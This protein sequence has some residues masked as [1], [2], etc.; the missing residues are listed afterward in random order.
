MRQ[1]ICKR[2]LALV[3]PVPL[4]LGTTA[5]G[6]QPRAN[7]TN[8][9]ASADAGLNQS[10][11]AERAN[12]SLRTAAE[13]FEAVTEQAFTAEWDRLDGL[14]SEADA[15]VGTVRP[16]L[17][18]E[19][20]ATIERQLSALHSARSAQDRNGIAMAAVESYRALVQAQDPGTAEPPVPVSLLDYA[21]F[22]YDALAQARSP[23]WPEML[24]L[25]EFARQQW[26]QV[27]SKVQSRAL[28]GVMDSTLAAM[29]SAA[30]R[31]DVEFARKSA[32]VELALVDLLEEQVSGT[33]G[34]SPG[35]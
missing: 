35:R 23:D 32:A 8:A 33:S 11:P 3:L 24:R 26:Q 4:L 1:L 22:R 20:A 6:P 15:A 30:E 25:T 17:S 31:K 7:E 27:A 5:C 2:L 19:A 16:R 12:Q 14:I 18:G 10:G 29:K 28:P 21:G 13:P 34:P 9:S